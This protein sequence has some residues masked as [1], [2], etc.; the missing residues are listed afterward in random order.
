MGENLTETEFEVSFF[1]GK[2]KSNAVWENVFPKLKKGY[3]TSIISNTHSGTYLTGLTGS[4]GIEGVLGITSGLPAYYSHINSIGGLVSGGE[5]VVSGQTTL[6]LPNLTSP[7]TKNE[8]LPENILTKRLVVIKENWENVF[9]IPSR[10]ASITKEN[11]QCE[12]LVDKESQVFETRSFPRVIFD[13]LIE[14]KKNKTVLI[15]IKSKKGSIRI[16]IIDGKGLVDESLFEIQDQWK[17]V[18][19]QF[20]SQPFKSG[21]A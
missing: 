13:D 8:E 17:R 18:K 5:S 3:T 16:D 7:Q 21:N 19:E 6:P 15:S 9:N 1:T 10:V 2:P 12:C 4:N 14:L 11:I 20:K